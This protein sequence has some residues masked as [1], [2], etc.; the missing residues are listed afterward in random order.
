MQVDVEMA[1]LKGRRL[2][3][4]SIHYPLAREYRITEP[5][6]KHLWEGAQTDLIANPRELVAQATHELLARF[7]FDLGLDV[8]KRLQEGIG[9]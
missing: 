9:R 8:I 3:P 2:L 6:W 5:A 4:E 7:G 1:N